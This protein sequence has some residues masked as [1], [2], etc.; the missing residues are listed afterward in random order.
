[1]MDNTIR[2]IEGE[3]FEIADRK[4]KIEFEIPI[5]VF[6]QLLRN[7]SVFISVPQA[8]TV[9][10]LWNYDS[11]ELKVLDNQTRRAIFYDLSRE[12]KKELDRRLKA[13]IT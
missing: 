2:H 3:R 1:M 9:W 8:V 6:R 11:F 12:S 13:L 10:S 5:A 7:P 4:G